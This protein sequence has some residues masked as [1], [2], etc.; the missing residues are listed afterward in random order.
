MEH[1]FTMNPKKSYQKVSK[2]RNTFN[3]H[4]A[5]H[6]VFMMYNMRDH[7]NTREIL[8]INT[9]E[10]CSIFRNFER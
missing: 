8:H 1:V 3:I 10:K 2:N 5:L 4:H 7:T 9:V 6:H